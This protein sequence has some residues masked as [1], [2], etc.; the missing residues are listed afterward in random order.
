M[1]RWPGEVIAGF[2]R[3][4]LFW[5]AVFAIAFTLLICGLDGLL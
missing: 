5:I 4:D 2:T 1:S 3:L